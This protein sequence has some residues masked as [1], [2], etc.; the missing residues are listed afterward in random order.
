MEKI[1]KILSF[2]LVYFTFYFLYAQNQQNPLQNYISL[3]LKKTSYKQVLSTISAISNASFV[4]KSSILPSGTITLEVKNKSL[5]K[6]LK[7]LFKN[8]SIIYISNGNEIIL[9]KKSTEK[10]NISGYVKDKTTKEPLPGVLIRVENIQKG[11]VSNAHGFYSLNLKIDSCILLYT[12]LGYEKI[13]KKIT[14]SGDTT[15]NCLLAEKNE[16]LEE[17]VIEDIS[18]SDDSFF[19]LPKQGGTNLYYKG[20]QHMS[21]FLGEQDL[22]KILQLLPGV[23]SS[24]EGNTGITVRGG[25]IDQNLILL[26][27]VPIYNSS[28]LF[29]FFSVFNPDIVKDASLYKGTIPARY[30]GKISSILDVQTREGNKYKTKL[31]GGIGTISGKLTFE[32]PL[33]K[34]KGSII[35]SLRRTHSDFLFNT[36]FLLSPDSISSNI[37]RNAFSFGDAFFK[38]TYQLNYKNKLQ[39]SV[40]YGRDETNFQRQLS[41][42]WDSDTYSL[43]WI[44]SI[45]PKLFSST[46]FFRSHILNRTI[47]Q[48]SPEL[49]NRR[50]YTLGSNGVKQDFLY[51]IDLDAYVDFGI[52]AIHHRYLF[53]EIFAFWISIYCAKKRR[54]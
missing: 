22:I 2:L 6:V 40:Y 14:L 9:K 30:G 45:N 1:Y 44:R 24:V 12:C 19:A 25:D 31:S 17:I 13:Y 11:T 38:G 51:Y 50:K 33:K 53:G 4:Y 48:F 47:D 46:T 32:T 41:N 39:I 42:K 21:S 36:L 20:V 34:G 29:G 43:R 10:F 52:E 23:Q 18:D 16:E 37:G 26:D 15:M 8:T 5:E 28:H 49:A 3:R 27:R 54:K 7:R 35:S